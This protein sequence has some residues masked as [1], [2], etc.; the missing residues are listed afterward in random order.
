MEHNGKKMNVG[1]TIW[2]AH[3]LV[4]E[5]VKIAW[6][7]ND[8]IPFEKLPWDNQVKVQRVASGISAYLG[9][10]L[11]DAE[12]FDVIGM[13][14]SSFD[15]REVLAQ[16]EISNLDV[17]VIKQSLCRMSKETWRMEHMLKHFKM[18]TDREQLLDVL[19]RYRIATEELENTFSGVLEARTGAYVGIN[20]VQDLY[21]PLLQKC[22]D[23]VDDVI[24]LLLGRTFHGSF[25]ERELIERHN[26]PSTT[27]SELL[28]WRIDNL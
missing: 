18:D 5:Y 25:T 8:S 4:K 7:A 1:T 13:V 3:R 11:S 26:Y 10:T 22:N 14:F 16:S 24:V 19:L 21:H 20:A 15:N 27:D 17:T 23:K 28:N 6:M 9:I 12:T 2:D